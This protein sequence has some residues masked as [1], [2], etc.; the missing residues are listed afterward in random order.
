MRRREILA[1]A[2]LFGLP[3]AG[4]EG[5]PLPDPALL[6]RDPETYWKRIRDEQFLLPDWRAFM[7]NGSL[8][9]TPRPVLKA[10]TDYLSQAAAL[11]ND[12]YPRWGYETL[13]DE[14]AELAAFAGCAKDELALTHNATEAMSVIANGID[15]KAGDEVLITDQEHPSG[16]EPWLLRQARYGIQVRVVNIPLP[17]K[18]SA[19][20]ADLLISAIG[21]RTRVLSFSGILTTTGL[22]MPVRAICDAARAKGV[23][24]VVDGAHMNGQIPLRLADLGCDYFAG[25]PHKWL[26]APAGC[27]LLY[28]R[29][30][31]LERLWP[32]IVT[33]AWSD[34][35]LKAARFM[36]IGTNN[37]AVVEGLM[38]GLRFLKAL[39][40]ERV[41]GR[42]HQLAR[43]VFERAR[44]Q[45]DLQL[46]TPADDRLYGGLVTFRM[47]PELSRAFNALCAKKRIWTTGGE[48]MRVATHIHTRPRDIDLFF[49]TLEEARRGST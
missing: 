49:Q 31:M 33:S 8:G 14:R 40:P 32:T 11:F 7:N 3:A 13:D 43:M 10:V 9:I 2:A 25:S 36:R 41:Y 44:G 38:A 19:Q 18:D 27:G 22:V 48:R 47:K 26:F 23:V 46:L 42:I 37:R 16:R 20:L 28:G 29:Q 1:G 21:P 5:A 12:D 39:G 34:Q 35:K 24:S 15:L 30:E 6:Q 45:S 17:P 4:A